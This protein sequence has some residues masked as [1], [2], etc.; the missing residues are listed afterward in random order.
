MKILMEIID[1]RMKGFSLE[2]IL[3]L[4][5]F[6]ILLSDFPSWFRHLLVKTLMYFM[7]QEM[8]AEKKE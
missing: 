2:I 1:C 7:Y 6:R 8:Q 4:L 5:Y 3:I